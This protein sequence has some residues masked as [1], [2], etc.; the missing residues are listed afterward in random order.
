M[1]NKLANSCDSWWV[2]MVKKWSMVIK[3]VAILAVFMI[4]LII[5]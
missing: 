5:V 3:I 4:G 2:I 1:V